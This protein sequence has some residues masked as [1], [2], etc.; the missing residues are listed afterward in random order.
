MWQTYLKIHLS[1]QQVQLSLWIQIQRLT[2]GLNLRKRVMTT[3]NQ[4]T[5]SLNW[6]TKLPPL[7]KNWFSQSSAT[8]RSTVKYRKA[9]NTLMSHHQKLMST[10]C[11][12]TRTKISWVGVLILVDSLRTIR[13]TI[14]RSVIKS[15]SSLLSLKFL[16]SST[17][18]LIRKLTSLLNTPQPPTFLILKFQQ[19]LIWEILVA[20]IMLAKSEIKEDVALAIHTPLSRPSRVDWEWST[21][22]LLCQIFPFSNWSLVI[23]WLRV[24]K[25]AG[26]LWM[27]SSLRTQV[28][29]KRF[30]L[31]TPKRIRL[32]NS[33]NVL[34]SL[35]WPRPTSFNLLNLASRRRS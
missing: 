11:G 16:N 32:V 33:L 1:W 12:S 14:N 4:N 29:S 15:L 34:K 8:L 2:M 28:S 21:V 9:Q 35:E 18:L 6:A 31:L 20:S 27:V 25:V 26:E 24:A 13:C 10:W 3:A 17:K 5:L 22:F 19:L 23:T 7:S 30:V